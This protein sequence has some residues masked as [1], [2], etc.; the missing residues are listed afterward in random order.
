MTP[1]C[2]ICVLPF[3][4]TL[5]GSLSCAK[6]Q[7]FLVSDILGGLGLSNSEYARLGEVVGGQDLGLSIVIGAHQV[8]TFL[9]LIFWGL[10]HFH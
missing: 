4:D 9:I 1:E 3:R 2:I 10:F 6:I 5:F 7:L 8:H